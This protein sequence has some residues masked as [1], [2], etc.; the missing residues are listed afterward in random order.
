MIILAIAVLQGHVQR[1]IDFYKKEGKFFAIGGKDTPW[2]DENNPD[3]PLETDYKL[4]DI[5]GYKRVDRCELVVRDDNGTISYRT[6]NWRV[7]PPPFHTKT[8]KGVAVGDTTIYVDSL[9]TGFTVGSKVRVG[10]TYE[11]KITGVNSSNDPSITLDTPAP[12][13]IPVS[14]RVEGGALVEGANCVFVECSLSY[15]QFPIGTYRQIGLCSEVTP[16]RPVLS[17]NDIESLGV[18]E[19]LDNRS[20]S[21]R[22]ADQKELLSLIIEY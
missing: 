12:S 16:D 20:P 2:R 5:M 13:T 3:N 17:P 6:Q 1:A 18:L 15:D 22:N 8:S 4:K 19:I 9:L 10:N 11:G 7:V 21:S 14:S